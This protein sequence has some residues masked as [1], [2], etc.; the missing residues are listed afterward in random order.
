MKKNKTDFAIILDVVANYFN[1]DKIDIFKRTNKHEIVVIRQWFHYLCV[2]LNP[3]YSVSL[4]SIGAFYS[5]ITLKPFDHATVLHS[6]KAIENYLFS[7][8]EFKDVKVELINNINKI[9]NQTLLELSDIKP[10]KNQNQQVLWYLYNW[11]KMSLKDVIND[12]MFYKF[13]SR[14]SD[15][16]F[17]HGKIAN[18][19]TIKFTNRFGRV[20]NY[21]VYQA[22]DKQKCKELFELYN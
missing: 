14:I 20:S 4:N 9:K 22:I 13:Q 2:V 3:K 18:R 7:D 19:E 12:S 8:I 6:K 21:T 10:P 17:E 1:I 15:I 11:K 5:D 16:E